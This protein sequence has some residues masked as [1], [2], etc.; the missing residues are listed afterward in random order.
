MLFLN[1]I[2]LY[3]NKLGEYNNYKQQYLI[4]NASFEPFSDPFKDWISSCLNEI[5]IA[6]LWNKPA[7]ISMHRVNFV[8]SLNPQNR[9]NNLKQ[10]SILIDSINKKWP[11]VEYMSTVDLVKTILG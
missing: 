9:T 8:G 10:F 11:Q 1:F 3:F 6:F 5:Q 2:I 7:V 4:R